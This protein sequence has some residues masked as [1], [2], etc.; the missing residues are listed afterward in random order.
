MAEASAL[1]ERFDENRILDVP[2]ILEAYSSDLSFVSR[3]RP[4]AVVFPMNGKE[5]QEIVGWANETMTPLIPVSSGSPHFR[6][7]TVPAMG[8]AVIMDL[9]RMKKILRVDPKNRVAMVEPGVTFGEL[10]PELE[11]AG[12]SAYLPLSPRSAKSVVGCMLE[13]EPIIIPSQHWDSLD[14][15]LCAE[16]VFGTGDKLRSGEAAGPDSIE[17]QWK[18]GKAQ[19]TPFGLGQFDESRLISG[20]QG[21]I[22]IVTWAT[23]KCRPLPE[24]KRAFLVPSETIE[25]LLDL[26][27]R[28]VRLKLGETCFIVN[29][30]SLASLLA[31][32]REEIESLREILPRWTLVIAFEGSGPLPKEKVTYQEADFRE[33]LAETSNLQARDA[34]GGYSADDVADLVSKPSS[35]PCW[36]LR[37]K[38]ACQEIFFLTTLD[39]T[40]DFIESMRVLARSRRFESGDIGVYIQPVVQGTSCHLEFDLFYDPT[41]PDETDRVKTLNVDGAVSLANLGAFFSRPYGPWA[42][43]AYGRAADTMILQRKVKKIFDPNNVLN[44]GKLCF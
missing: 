42:K 7:D 14:P 17:D 10:Q 12:L 15:L 22:G 13:R 28:L 2:E 9:S 1:K 40:P 31:L 6:G 41:D 30:L 4:R 26:S 39:R 35:D 8:G 23:L 33:L 24:L 32:T 37:C 11:K 34:L 25:P 20:A 43:I 5:V 38:G 19:M 36:K 27:Y 16:I 18:I 21:A 29:G 3:M 44:P